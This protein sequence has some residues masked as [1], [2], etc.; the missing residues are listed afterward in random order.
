V[1]LARFRVVPLTHRVAVGVHDDAPDERV[2]ENVAGCDLRE[3]E[4]A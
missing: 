3:L 4:R 2:G 1:R